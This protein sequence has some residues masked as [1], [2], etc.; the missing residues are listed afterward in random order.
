MIESGNK[1]NLTLRQLAEG[2]KSW[3]MTEAA[4]VSKL[5]A[6][7]NSMEMAAANGLK[8]TDSLHSEDRNADPFITYQKEVRE[9]GSQWW[10]ISLI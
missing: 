10:A 7:Y 2:I 9:K 8:L 1:K 5:N 3:N 6:Y 4:M